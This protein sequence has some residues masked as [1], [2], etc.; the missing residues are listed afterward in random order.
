MTWQQKDR[1]QRERQAIEG[2][3]GNQGRRETLATGSKRTRERQDWRTRQVTEGVTEERR[4]ERL[5]TGNRDRGHGD[6]GTGD[7]SGER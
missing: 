4:G 5:S 3:G 7:R 2:E 6:Q 1:G